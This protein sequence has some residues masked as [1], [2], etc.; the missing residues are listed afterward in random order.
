MRFLIID[1]NAVAYQS[2]YA[3]QEIR[4]KTGIS[5]GALFGFSKKLLMILQK[6]KPDHVIAAFDSRGKK[7]KHGMYAE[8]KANRKPM[9]DTMVSQMPLIKEFLDNM[10]IVVVER[11]GQ[12]ADDL[13]GS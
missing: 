3:F 9:P 11:P 1:S 10:K 13:I 7:E 4:T 5:V 12:E 6:V 2:F 8:Y